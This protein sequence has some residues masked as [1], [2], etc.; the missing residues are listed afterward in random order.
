MPIN[1]ATD[2]SK[3]N[4]TLAGSWDCSRSAG[5]IDGR[6]CE[7]DSQRYLNVRDRVGESVVSSAPHMERPENTYMRADPKRKRRQDDIDPEARERRRRQEE[8]LDNALEN[9]FPASD[10]I[11]V[12]QPAPSPDRRVLI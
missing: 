9:T 6:R 1:A 3:N 12:E 11:S 10:P 5:G 2:L 4:S 7:I 8:A